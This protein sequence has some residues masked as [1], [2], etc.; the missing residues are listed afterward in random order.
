MLR[1]LAFGG[2]TAKFLA[3]PERVPSTRL[4]GLALL[5]R[6]AVAGER[7]A[8]RDKLIGCFWP[9]KDERAALHSL[10]QAIH[11][12]RHDLGMES[13]LLGTRILRLDPSCVSSDVGELEAAYRAGDSAR[14]VE[15]YAG[16]F[17]DGIYVNDAPEFD[18]WVDVERRQYA[19][20]HAGA[21]R[22]LAISATQRGDHADAAR[23]WQRLLTQDPLNSRVTLELLRSLS[24]DGSDGRALAEAN[25]HEI[26]IRRELKR[27]PDADIA[28]FIADH[29]PAARLKV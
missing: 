28:A 24:A 6:L 11:R 2:L 14:V 1:L 25:R 13:L 3:N 23:W 16:P 8:S 20:L 17:L 10:S 9:D 22:R 15:L 27:S 4:Q 19:D 7:G 5:A 12:L 18:R 29:R 21:L 26:L